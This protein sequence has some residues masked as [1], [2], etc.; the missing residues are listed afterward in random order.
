MTAIQKWESFISC[1][2]VAN[3]IKE[4][5]NDPQIRHNIEQLAYSAFCEGILFE[6]QNRVPIVQQLK[7][8]IAALLENYPKDSWKYDSDRVNS[9]LADLRRLST[10]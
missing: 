6:R 10:V 2:I 8:E 4:M 9:L 5:S 3:G 1:A 7:A